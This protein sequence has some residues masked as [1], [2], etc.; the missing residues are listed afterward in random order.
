MNTPS[1]QV[2]REIM[3]NVPPWLGGAFYAC[4]FAALGWAAFAFYRRAQRH[5][6]GRAQPHNA[7]RSRGW[8]PALRSAAVYLTFHRQLLRDRYAGVAHLL[9]FYGFFVLFIGTCL[10]FLEHDTP[11]HFFYGWF[12]R[13]ASLLIDLGGAAMLVGL[14]M[15][16]WRRYIAWQGEDESHAVRLLRAWWVAAL[17]WLLL[18]IGITGFLLEGA[19]IARDFPA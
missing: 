8:L 18:I 11:L 2:T 15:F 5:R 7:H 14:G 9:T 12:Y 3:G 1:E 19:R 6:A 10:V 16:L 17:A 4:A 13:V